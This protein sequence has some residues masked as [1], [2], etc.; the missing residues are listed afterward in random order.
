MTGSLTGSSMVSFRVGDLLTELT[1]RAS[2]SQVGAVCRRDLRR[3]YWLLALARASAPPIAP[4][5]EA[6]LTRRAGAALAAPT[7]DGDLTALVFAAVDVLPRGEWGPLQ[8]LALAD[9]LEYEHRTAGAPL[10]E[11][12]GSAPAIAAR[13]T[14][15]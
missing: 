7:A 12:E 14:R 8:L 9:R 4:H 13:R 3:Y 6:L 15:P 2:P 11:P 5:V 1:R 10:E